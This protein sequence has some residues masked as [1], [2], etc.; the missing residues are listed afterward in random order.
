M[1]TRRDN[2]RQ[3]SLEE[4]TPGDQSFGFTSP[5]LRAGTVHLDLSPGNVLG[6]RFKI[7][8]HLGCGA[9]GDVYEAR[10]EL[11]CQILALKVVDD[12]IAGDATELKQELALN[13]RIED[14][15]YVVQLYDYYEAPFESTQ[16]RWLTMELADGGSLRERL[17]VLTNDVAPEEKLDVYRHIAQGVA[18][19][20]DAGVIH[21]DL[22]PENIL[23]FADVPKVSDVSGTRVVGKSASS[24]YSAPELENTVDAGLATP[25]ADVY[26]LGIILREL[27]QSELAEAPNGAYRHDGSSQADPSRAEP[28]S[29]TSVLRSVALR[30]L[31]LDPKNRYP[32]ATD[33]LADL[34]RLVPASGSKDAEDDAFVNRTA[35]RIQHAL[36]TDSLEEASTLCR[37]LL[38]RAPG[39]DAAAQ[40]LNQIES[41]KETA[42]QLY[43]VIRT[44][45]PDRD[46]KDLLEL[47]HQA[48]NIF[49]GH[50]DGHA[51]QAEL[52]GKVRKF[53]QAMEEGVSAVQRADWRSA[54]THFET[55]HAISPGSPGATRALHFV[56]EVREHIREERERIDRAIADGNRNGALMH[57]EA[58]DR[59]IADCIAAQRDEVSMDVPYEAGIDE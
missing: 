39:N 35:C 26:S 19:L 27:L 38:D 29:L 16:L 52:F 23:F 51:V 1:T 13:R 5:P 31:S 44:G 7:M 47:L 25:A 36:D 43:N 22:R 3:A 54:T 37:E 11:T 32:S 9:N 20:H 10:D 49:P 17:P 57:A 12:G 48:V 34:N 53:R 2:N 56:L 21:F 42:K 50:P 33:L 55:A 59:Y 8:D 18:A 4:R 6:G 28:E 46:V 45:L 15:Q 24:I 14:H 30:C 41:R 58:L 40:L